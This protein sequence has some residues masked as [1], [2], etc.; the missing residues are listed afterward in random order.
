MEAFV[1]LYW[2]Y[3]VNWAG[4]RALSAD[5]DAAAAQSRTI[6]YQ[7]E[8]VRAWVSDEA[9]QLVD[10]ITFMD[11]SPDRP[12]DAVHEAVSRV[13]PLCLA[14]NARVVIARFGRWRQHHFLHHSLS[15]LG[16]DFVELD[17]QPM[18][19]DGIL[20]EPIEHFRNW[21]T[22]NEAASAARRHDAIAALR[23]AAREIEAGP[24][25]FQKIAEHL[26]GIDVKTFTGKEWTSANVKKALVMPEVAGA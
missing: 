7:M 3:P 5:V 20:F 24:G 11:T 6:R 14:H 25:R 13:H 17:P 23:I 15:D 21:S 26:N 9:G 10:E 2:T 4:F 12:T 19:I 16:I 1:G 22:V 18:T 8:R